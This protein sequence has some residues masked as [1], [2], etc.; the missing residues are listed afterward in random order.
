MDKLDI[1]K[2]N[3]YI[4][5]KIN[6]IKSEMTKSGKLLY[7]NGRHSDAFIYIISGNCTYVFDDDRSIT[8]KPGDILYLAHY[9]VYSM[10]V[11]TNDYKFI[12]CDFEFYDAPARVSNVYSPKNEINTDGLFKKL[13]HYYNSAEKNS[14]PK[15]M[16]ILYD[17]YCLVQ[18]TADRTYISQNV[19]AKIAQ[20]KN[21]NDFGYGDLS[22]S[23]SSL[24]KDAGMS[25]VYFRKLF[26]S[27]Y[28][29]SPSQYILSVRLKNAKELMKYPFLSLEECA[30]QSGF[31]T[32]QYFCRVFKK[33]TGMS[34]S[35][36]IKT[37]EHF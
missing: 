33:E 27:Q 26:K 25:E 1:V 37:T 17:I 22:L 12:F 23:V 7:R 21:K 10:Y 29:I 11:H 13:F 19:H 8:V 31:S 3:L 2:S 6:V 20:A 16:S 5:K 9:A 34:P 24:A 35:E 15:C 32:Q 18:S 4:T 28:N 14:F 36:Y 30:C